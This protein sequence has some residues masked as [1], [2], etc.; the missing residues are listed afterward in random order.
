MFKVGD[1]VVI[2]GCTVIGHVLKIGTIALVVGIRREIYD[3]IGVDEFGD[4]RQQG[5][6]ISD[7]RPLTPLDK[8]MK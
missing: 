2:T 6:F 4:N 8:A 1:E 7:I 3:L 5:L